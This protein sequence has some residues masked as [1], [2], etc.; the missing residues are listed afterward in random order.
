M[1]QE[2]SSCSELTVQSG[3]ARTEQFYH[4]NSCKAPTKV[5]RFVQSFLCICDATQ[6]CR[7]SHLPTKQ[8]CGWGNTS[9]PLQKLTDVHTH[10]QVHT[11]RHA[12]PHLLLSACECSHAAPCP[13]LVCMLSR[14]CGLTH[15]SPDRPQSCTRSFLVFTLGFKH[16]QTTPHCAPQVWSRRY[17]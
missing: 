4:A 17:H 13:L 10:M 5:H 8:K 16:P 11:L 12:C 9:D 1:A 15:T 6:S 2:A 14:L 3:S 7:N